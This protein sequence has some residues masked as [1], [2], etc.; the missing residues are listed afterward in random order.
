MAMNRQT[1]RAMAKQGADKPARPERRSP[2]QATQTERTGPRQYLSEVRGEMKKVAWPPRPE[3]VNS[4]II[5]V[6]GLVVM[7]ALIFFF[8]WASV[9][10]VD[11]VFK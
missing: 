2:S 8:D 9:H 6:I 5:V 11:F 10:V 4:T 3:I 7:T 1:K